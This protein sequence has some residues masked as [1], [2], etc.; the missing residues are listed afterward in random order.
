M[1]SRKKLINLQKKENFIFSTK[2]RHFQQPIC[3]LSSKIW[4]VLANSVCRRRV[5]RLPSSECPFFRTCSNESF[6]FVFCPAFTF[7]FLFCIWVFF[8]NHKKTL[9]SSNFFFRRVLALKSS[10]IDSSEDFA[11]SDLFCKFLRE[12]FPC[13]K[14]HFPTVHVLVSHLVR[15]CMCACLWKC[16]CLYVC[17]CVSVCMCVYVWVCVRVCMCECV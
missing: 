6:V 17:I 14:I 12:I 3:S 9:P 2:L 16:V 15:V 7:H 4:R 10:A 13:Q 8:E 1:I 11:F 5:S